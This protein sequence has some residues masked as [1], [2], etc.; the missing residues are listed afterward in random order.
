M[1]K[2][3]PH[4]TK[5]ELLKL[6]NVSW[7][8]GEVPPAWKLATIIP[9]KKPLKDKLDPQSY[10]PI[11]LTSCICKTM[12]TMIA[13]RLSP[14]LEKNYLIS[15]TQSGFRPGRSTLDQC[16]RLQSE[17]NMAFMERK[18]LIATYLDIEKAFYL[19]WSTRTLMQLQKHGIT[20]KMF[21]W[22]RRFLIGRK[23]QL[24]VGNTLSDQYDL[25]NG[26][27]QDSVISS[28]LFNRIINTLHTA[29]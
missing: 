1:L 4:E 11:S 26:C 18:V 23:I 21:Q 16:T 10:R 29:L 5:I 3:L 13:N 12:E 27:L 25:E 28:I 15:N 17:V 7:E 14:F 19:M 6:I 24:R 2:Q 22:I 8:R 20:G 9:I